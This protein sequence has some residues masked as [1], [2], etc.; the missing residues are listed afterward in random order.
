MRNIC[1]NSRVYGTIFTETQSTFHTDQWKLS[2]SFCNVKLIIIEM[3]S[4]QSNSR[5]EIS[6][7]RH[8]KE[9]E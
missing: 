8:L 6:D 2:P 7:T 1:V 5:A 3:F 4:K 9:P